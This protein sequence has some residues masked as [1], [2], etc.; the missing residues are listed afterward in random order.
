MS[1]HSACPYHSECPRTR[2]RKIQ[3][4]TISD[5]IEFTRQ[6]SLP[7]TPH[8][9]GITVLLQSKDNNRAAD[10]SVLDDAEVAQKL[11]ISKTLRRRSDETEEQVAFSL[12]QEQKLLYKNDLADMDMANGSWNC[13]NCGTNNLMWDASCWY[14]CPSPPRTQAISHH[15][16]SACVHMQRISPHGKMRLRHIHLPSDPAR[17]IFPSYRAA[18]YIQDRLRRSL[19]AAKAAS[20]SDTTSP[21]PPPPPPTLLTFTPQP[22]YTLGRRQSSTLL[23]PR[24]LARLSA[25]LHVAPLP[26]PFTPAV[27]PSPRGGL[28]TYHGPGQLVLWPVLDLRSR[29]LARPPQQQQPHTVRS[30]AALLQDTTATILRSRFGLAPFT[31]ED[32][33][34]WVRSPPTPTP[35]GS[36]G[37]AAAAAEEEE[38]AEGGELRKIAAMGVHLRRHVT[39]L[40]VA[41]NLCTPTTRGSGGRAESTTTDHHSPEGQDEAANPWARFVACGLEGKGVTCVREELDLIRHHHHH[42]QDAAPPP[43]PWEGDPA[44]LSGAADAW[45][46]E[47]AQRLGLGAPWRLGDGAARELLAAA[48]EESRRE[49]E[50]EEAITEEGVQ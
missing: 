19:L 44:D 30:Y 29:D 6:P 7:L 49:A 1:S 46:A 40:G 38:E 36:A 27:L 25:P 17:G 12:K 3:Y 42:R 37:G 20:S 47:L 34:V 13:C 22:T 45:A 5:R 50:M 43:S 28:T 9:S 31:T 16:Q 41:V 18:A 8:L 48:E 15:Q 10:K 11:A 35:G 24:T 23:P 26:S 39:G 32:P 2:A 4:A 33:G 14:Y 21:Q